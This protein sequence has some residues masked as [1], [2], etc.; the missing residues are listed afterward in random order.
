ML[1]P[2]VNWVPFIDVN[3]ASLEKKLLYL[4]FHLALCKP[5]VKRQCPAML[6]TTVMRLHL[7]YI[8]LS[9]VDETLATQ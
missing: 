3:L 2:S 7:Y 5:N 4:C 9:L 8:P 1:G 6:C